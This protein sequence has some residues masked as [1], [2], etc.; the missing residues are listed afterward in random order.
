MMRRVDDQTGF[1]LIEGMVAAAI[2]TVGLL[3]LAAMQ[4]ISMSRNVD[5]NELTMAT[6]LAGEMVERIQTNRMQA[7][8]YAGMQ[9][10]PPVIPGGAT[11]QAVGDLN[12]WALTLGTSGLTN[13]VGTVAVAAVGPVGLNQQAVQVRVGWTAKEAGARPRAVVVNTIIARE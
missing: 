13:P 11:M 9:T 3:A 10:T 1:T 12:Q 5:A 2:L 7:I 4:S 6:N 8:Q